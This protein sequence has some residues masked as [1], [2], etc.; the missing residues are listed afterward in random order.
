MPTRKWFANIIVALAGLLTAWATTGGWNQE[1]TVVL[2]GILSAAVVAWLVP[3]D[4]AN[5]ASG[6]PMT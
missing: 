1:E 4:P 6:G 5:P 2:I 3:N